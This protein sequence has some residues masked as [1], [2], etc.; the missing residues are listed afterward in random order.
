[1]NDNARI[2]ASVY[3]ISDEDPPFARLDLNYD[4]YTANA[5]GRMIKIGVQ[6]RF[7]AGPFQ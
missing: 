3:N 6:W 4:P 1:M 7:E 5:F 2:F